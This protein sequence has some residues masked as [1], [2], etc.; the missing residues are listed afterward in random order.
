MAKSATAIK[1]MEEKVTVFAEQLGRLLGTV[2]GRAEGWLERQTLKDDLI[3]VRD[4]AARLLEQLTGG[5]G[6]VVATKSPRKKAGA[7]A[8]KGR[9]GGVVDAPGKRHRKPVP[10]V[11]RVSERAPLV[12]RRHGRDRDQRTRGANRTSRRLEFW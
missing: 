2:Q 7:A 10:S 8:D 1:E 9:S 4:S 12:V 5:A 11:S 6:T 3:K